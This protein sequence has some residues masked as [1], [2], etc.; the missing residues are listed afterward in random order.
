[1]NFGEPKIIQKPEYNPSTLIIFVDSQIGKEPLIEAIKE[2]N[3]EVLYDYKIMNS[4]AIKIPTNKTIEESI[5]YFQ[6]VK[7]VLQVNRDQISYLHEN[8]TNVF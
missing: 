5:E 3:A 7:G 4:M 6:N 8:N 2:Y 1:M